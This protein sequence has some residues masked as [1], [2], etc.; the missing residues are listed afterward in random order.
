MTAR[1][2]SIDHAIA[3]ASLLLAI[4]MPIVAADLRDADPD[5]IVVAA[6]LTRDPDVVLDPTTAL[7]GREKASKAASEDLGAIRA[8]AKAATD[9]T[10][11]S[12]GRADAPVVVEFMD[13]DCPHCRTFGTTADR[14]VAEGRIRLVVVETPILSDASRVLAEYAAA[15]SLQGRFAP[16]HRILLQRRAPDVASARSL[17][18]SLIVGADLDRAAFDRSLSD[19]SAS[20]LVARSLVLAEEA[21][22]TGTPT[23][24]AGGSASRGATGRER[25]LR[26]LMGS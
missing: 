10:M 26:M 24:V 14:L 8:A 16:A 18:P 3:A 21:R 12:I 11:P 1:P 13:Y 6:A 19:G 23:V 5:R 17:L 4:G 22:I 9:P 15:A 25:L 20:R 7:A 2:S